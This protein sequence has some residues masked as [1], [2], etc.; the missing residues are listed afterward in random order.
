M[1]DVAVI[2]INYNTAKFTLEAIQAV[3][4]HTA[5]ELAYQIIVV[6]NN[7]EEED[8]RL[9]ADGFPK[10]DHISLHPSPINTGFGGG[11]MYGV[12]HANARYL[13]F[14]NND[15][16]LL[17]DCL[18]LLTHFMDTHE[19]V[20]VC[21][22]QNYDEHQQF[23]PSFDHDKGLRRLL[24]GRGFLEKL[25]PIKYPKRKQEYTEPLE[26][27]WVNG[28]FLFFRTEAFKE[29]GGF[30]TE[31][32]LYFEEMDICHRLRKLGYSSMLVPAA[33]ILHYQ[34]V[35][36]GKSEVINK[37]GYISYLHVI[38][39]NYGG[40]KHAIVSLYLTLV[41]LIK[42]KKWYLLSTVL[43]PNRGRNSLKHLQK[44]RAHAR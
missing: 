16:M 30:D 21:T 2:M 25:N 4:D 3:Q 23:V 20:G 28:A 27:N 41:F 26:V 42:P 17:N 18:S 13:L 35:S 29:A 37:E 22:A 31:M 1:F 6:D 9:L 19:K 33:K 36:I 34:G 7:S 5:P 44:V 12:P 14:L 24:F 15:A 11:N 40:F 39:K 43:N 32:F 38:R 8:Y 10:A